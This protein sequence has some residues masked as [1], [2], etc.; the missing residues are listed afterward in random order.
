MCPSPA[1]VLEWFGIL[2][3]VTAYCMPVQY[4]WKEVK[5]PYRACYY[6]LISRPDGP[7]STTNHPSGNPNAWYCD[8]GDIYRTTKYV[9]YFELLFDGCDGGCPDISVKVTGTSQELLTLAG[10][11]RTFLLT[12]FP[13]SEV[14]TLSFL[15]GYLRG[16]FS[17]PNQGDLSWTPLVRTA[18]FSFSCPNKL[19]CREDLF[20]P[21][22]PGTSA[23]P[24]TTVPGDCC[25][26]GAPTTPI[27]EYNYR[28]YPPEYSARY[29]RTFR[30][31]NT[32]F[33]V[34]W[35][36]VG[37]YYI[38]ADGL[39]CISGCF[40]YPCVFFESELET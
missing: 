7:L 14:P 13:S 6:G 38:D 20:V 18:P 9:E 24:L 25:C 12:H 3:E 32:E 37:D 19:H 34:G 31:S 8:Y 39:H 1:D 4:N 11:I 10:Q 17:T 27:P 15:H 29:T 28:Y 16:T 26:G 23:A 36:I 5:H 33:P 2:P 22:V 35:V 30:F 21:L 40:V